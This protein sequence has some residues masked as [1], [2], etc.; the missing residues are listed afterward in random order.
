MMPTSF[1]DAVG[2]YYLAMREV[3]PNLT[4][5]TFGRHARVCRIAFR[6]YGVDVDVSEIEPIAVRHHVDLRLI[7]GTLKYLHS[8]GA[9]TD[10]SLVQWRQ[11][12]AERSG[13]PGDGYAMTHEE[14]GVRL[15]IPTGRVKGIEAEALDKM[16]RRCGN[17]ATELLDIRSDSPK[18]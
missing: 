17:V 2:I 16:R 5:A 18:S 4:R 8:I 13:A 14:I 3:D 12:R 7:N 10:E 15:G 11:R 1:A 6:E 9:R